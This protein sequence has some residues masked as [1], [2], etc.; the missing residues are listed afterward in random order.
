M[1]DQPCVCT[2]A[3]LNLRELE[4]K[5]LA[6]SYAERKQVGK[7]RDRKEFKRDRKEKYNMRYREK[8]TDRGPSS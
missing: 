5:G 1:L 2:T 7:N 4:R 8:K 3:R 6:Q